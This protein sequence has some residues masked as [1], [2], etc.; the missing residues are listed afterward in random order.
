MVS[1]SVVDERPQLSYDVA[2]PLSFGVK[3]LSQGEDVGTS[4][5]W[6]IVS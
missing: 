1:R 4:V 6:S 3:N 2:I 5:V